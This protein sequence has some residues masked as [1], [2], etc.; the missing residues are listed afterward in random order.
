[1]E[2]Y[3]VGIPWSPDDYDDIKSSL[4]LTKK[5]TTIAPHITLCGEIPNTVAFEGVPEGFYTG[6][7]TDK[8]VD[9]MK[10]EQMLIFD[11][12]KGLCIFLGCSHP[13]VVNCLNYA[14]KQFPGREIDTL[15]AG[16]HLDSASPS[17]LQMTIQHM[18][19]LDIHRVVPLHCT[20]IF[21]ISEMKRFLGSRCLPL[22][23]GDSLEI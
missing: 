20:G 12:E 15:V 3:E 13:G 4:V 17:R 19:D 1:K 8:T 6:D 18:I 9:M 21:A 23:A 2:F 22:C 5:N 11:T 7:K 14:L 10:D 16:M